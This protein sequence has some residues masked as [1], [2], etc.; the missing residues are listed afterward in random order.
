[1]LR[2]HQVALLGPGELDRLDGRE[3]PVPDEPYPFAYC[4]FTSG[5]GGRAKECLLT[6]ENIL[7]GLRTRSAG[8][9]L[10]AGD[11]AVSWLPLYHDMG[12]VGYLLQPLVTGF[13]CHVMSP[14]RFLRDP[15]SWLTLIARVGG[16]ISTAPNLAYALCTR[17]ISD[18]Q[19]AGL[20]LR[21]GAVRSTA[22]SR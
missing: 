3:D 5:T 22:P 20:D 15:A 12:L 7:A 8:Y 19:L 6:H 13:P 2:A 14:L 18:Q 10:G 11:V 17:K 4:L 21:A 1:M 9:G 16:T